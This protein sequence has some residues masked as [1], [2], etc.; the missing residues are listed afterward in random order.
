M[1]Q[2]G[3]YAAMQQSPA[4][5]IPEIDDEAAELEAQIDEAEQALRMARQALAAAKPE[6]SLLCVRSLMT[7]ARGWLAFE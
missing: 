5:S 7:E 1:A 4:Y 3:T 6:Q 2:I